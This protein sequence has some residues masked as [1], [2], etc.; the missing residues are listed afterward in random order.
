MVI[1]D[2]ARSNRAIPAAA[3]A[4]NNVLPAPGVRLLHVSASSGNLDIAR[5]GPGIRGG[6]RDVD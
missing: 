6:E 3:S 4:N 5:Y 2:S 1:N